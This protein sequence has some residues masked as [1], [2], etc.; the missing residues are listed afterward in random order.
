MTDITITH[1]RS[2]GN[3]HLYITGD[4]ADCLKALLG[5]KTVNLSDLKNLLRL[6]VKFDIDANAQT[7]INI[8]SAINH[9]AREIVFP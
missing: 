6:G 8:T 1:K 9:N 2:Y 4:K 7:C 5:K 3:D